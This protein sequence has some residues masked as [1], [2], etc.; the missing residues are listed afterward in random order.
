MGAFWTESPCG[1]EKEKMSVTE[2]MGTAQ[3]DSESI[4]LESERVK[5]V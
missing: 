3:K 4:A 5:I 1:K 2:R